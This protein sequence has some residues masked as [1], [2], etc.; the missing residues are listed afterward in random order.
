MEKD[1]QNKHSM[2]L[3]KYWINYLTIIISFVALSFSIV[4]VVPC[5]IQSLDYIAVLVTILG[6]IV[7]TVIGYQIYQ[8]LDIKKKIN[9]ISDLEVK[10]KTQQSQ[11]EDIYKTVKIDLLPEQFVSSADTMAMH[12]KA[13]GQ[14]CIY[15]LRALTIKISFDSS[16]DYSELF[17]K[18]FNN[19]SHLDIMA[20]KSSKSIILDDITKET[21]KLEEVANIDLTKKLQAYR[22]ALTILLTTNPEKFKESPDSFFREEYHNRLESLMKS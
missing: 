19:S 6:I 14:S 21:F 2:N 9:K 12:P 20:E 3:K 18:L 16:Y 11:I 8:T 22:H 13:M 15:L 5:G 17:E 10:L 4:R 1:S 7:T